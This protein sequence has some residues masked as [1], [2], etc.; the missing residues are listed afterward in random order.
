[1]RMNAEGIKVLISGRLN[2]AEMAFRGFKDGRVPINFQILIHAL[3]KHTYHMVEWA[4]K[5]GS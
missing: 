5:C 4:S 1:M 2:G 3:L